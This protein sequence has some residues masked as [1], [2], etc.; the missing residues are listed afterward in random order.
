[1]AGLMIPG[2]VPIVLEIPIRMA[3]YWGA[4]SKWLTENPA[5][6]NP[7]IKEIYENIIIKYALYYIM[8]CEYSW[9]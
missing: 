5:Q 3:A 2:M 8:H 9:F 4:T 6:A 7:K 1:M